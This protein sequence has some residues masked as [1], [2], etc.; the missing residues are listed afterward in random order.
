MRRLCLLTIILALALAPAVKAAYDPLGGGT[1]KLV[2]DKGFGRFLQ[3]D[4]VKL[5]AAAGTRKK[6]SSY[7]LGIAGGSLDPTAGKGEIDDEGT[8]IFQNE[9]K[10]VPLRAITIKTKHS[11]LTAKVGGSQLKVATSAGLSFVREGFDS[12]FTA[13]KLRL[14]AKV[15]TRLNKK[16]R[17]KVPFKAGQLL[18]TLVSKPKPKLVTIEAKNRA[19]LVFDPAFVKKLDGRFVSLNPIFP[20]EHLGATFTFPIAAGGS[21]APDA[22]EGTLRTGGEVEMLQL[23]AGQVFWKEEW[24]D[25]GAR[26]DSAEVDVEPAPSFPGKLGRVGVLVIGQGAVSSN[27]RARTISVSGAPLTLTV[28]AAATL[29]EAF[30]QNEP[31]VFFASEAAG[32]LSFTAQGQ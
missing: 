18:G 32:A 27:P 23:H 16:L 1:T 22:T 15:I 31:P 30:A 5:A 13:S 11:P 26:Q 12:S 24:F 21:L 25:H 10:K 3:E 2:L 4:G 28:S 9:R 20:A 7:L 8:L 29:N 14:T 17:P 19:T 6:G